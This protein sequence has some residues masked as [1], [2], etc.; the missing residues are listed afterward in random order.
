MMD[1]VRREV[2]AVYLLQDRMGVR[3]AMGRELI[4]AGYRV[5][6]SATPREF[7]ENYVYDAPGCLVLVLCMPGSN[8]QVRGELADRGLTPQIVHISDGVDVAQAL[9]V[10]KCETSDLVL[11]PARMET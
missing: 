7:F 1:A 4:A 9:E 8:E 3:K 10:A 5:F 11:K 2:P 6:L